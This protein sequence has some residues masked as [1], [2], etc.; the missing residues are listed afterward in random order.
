MTTTV[1][2]DDGCDAWTRSTIRKHLWRMKSRLEFDDLYS[3]AWLVFDKVSRRYTDIA[4]KHLMA[5]YKTSLVNRLFDLA[6]DCSKHTDRLHDDPEEYEALVDTVQGSNFFT[7]VARIYSDAD[8]MTKLG[9]NAAFRETAPCE[10]R[11]CKNLAFDNAMGVK[12]G[13]KLAS[14]VKE[15]LRDRR[16]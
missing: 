4:D 9:L 13:T 2:L 11:G 5:I 1:F 15:E 14:R 16:R 10:Y 7:E 3:E 12:R 6:R 8:D